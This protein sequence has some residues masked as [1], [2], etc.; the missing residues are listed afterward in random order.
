MSEKKLIY[1]GSVKDIYQLGDDLIFKFSDRYSIFDWGAMPDEI[2]G[3]GNTLAWM[4][5]FFFRQLNYPHHG[6]FCCDREGNETSDSTSYFKVKAVDVFRPHFNNGVYDY[7]EYQKKPLNALVPL[8]V[9]FR[10]GIPKGSSLISR[11]KDRDYCQ[12]IGLKRVYEV[13]EVL[14]SPLIE[15]STKLESTDRYISYSEAQSIAGLSDKEF[16]RLLNDSVDNAKRL[17]EI[18]SEIGIFL[19]DGKFEYAFS[20]N[21]STERSFILVDSVGPD[22]L[23][24]SYD[25]MTLSK[26]FLRS[27]YRGHEWYLNLQEAKKIAAERGDEDWKKVCLNEF[28]STPPLLDEKYKKTAEMIYLTLANELSEKWDGKKIFDADNLSELKIRFGALS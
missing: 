21:H 20:N 11:M 13:G 26:E 25:G 1:S 8:E 28:K 2:D 24:L 14:E 17:K 9:V 18:F 16:N 3:K 19:W 7:S 15:F 22:E 5:N 4:A 10:F 12:S 6:Y 23:R 27:Y